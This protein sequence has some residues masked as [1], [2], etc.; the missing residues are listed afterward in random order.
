M[1]FIFPAIV[2]A[3]LV[4]IWVMHPPARRNLSLGFWV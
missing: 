4:L 2:V 1:I 3:A